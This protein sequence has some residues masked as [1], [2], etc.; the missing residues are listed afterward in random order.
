MNLLLQQSEIILS[1]IKK[2]KQ[3]LKSIKKGEISNQSVEQ[4]G[5]ARVKQI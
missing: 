5:F 3:E 4:V 1:E 2:L